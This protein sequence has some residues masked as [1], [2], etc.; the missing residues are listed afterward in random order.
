MILIPLQFL[1]LIT[2]GLMDAFMTH[3]PRT[4]AEWSVHLPFTPESG[5]LDLTYS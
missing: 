1:L 5:Q 3:L 2:A 4:C